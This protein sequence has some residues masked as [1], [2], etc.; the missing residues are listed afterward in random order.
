MD[1]SQALF[2]VLYL[3]TFAGAVVAVRYVVEYTKDQVRRW[4]EPFAYALCWAWVILY[5]SHAILGKLGGGMWFAD[6]FSG[7]VVAAAAG[8]MQKPKGPEQPQG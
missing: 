7:F 6:F 3:A 4:I 2:T 5:G 1:D 8:G